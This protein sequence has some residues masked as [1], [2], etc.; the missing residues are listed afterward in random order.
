[1]KS[2]KLL[3]LLS[4]WIMPACKK[5]TLPAAGGNILNKT[6]VTLTGQSYSQAV[7]SFVY[8]GQQRL[9][10]IIYSGSNSFSASF[11]DTVTMQY[12][13]SGRMSSW[14]MII[15]G[16]GMVITYELSYDGNGRLVKATAVPLLPN[17]A[18]SDYSFAY[19]AQG[20]LVADTAYLQHLAGVPSPGIMSYDNWTYDDNGNAIADQPFVTTNAFLGGAPFTGGI[21]DTYQYDN[22]VNP[23]YQAG[24]PFFSFGSFGP[25]L[26]SPNNQVGGTTTDTSALSPYTFSYSYYSNGRPKVQNFAWI[27]SGDAFA[28][29]TAYFY[30]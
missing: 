5:T 7:D 20:H 14:T 4:L 6:T 16:Q 24:I 21:T 18:Y 13:A 12:D 27:A 11:T 2:P 29:T 19:D 26:L 23:Y 10:E 22:R 15:G 30:Q 28:Q 9:A 8:D 3:L 1:M 25:Q 17:I